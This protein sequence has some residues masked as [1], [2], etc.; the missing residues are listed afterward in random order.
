MRPLNELGQ[1]TLPFP[2]TKLVTVRLTPQEATLLKQ[3]LYAA[4][5]HL[6]PDEVEPVF[7]LVCRQLEEG[8]K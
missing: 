6:P 1:F 3:Y 4:A 8:L 2:E 5:R 7:D